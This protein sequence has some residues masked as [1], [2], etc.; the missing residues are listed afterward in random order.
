MKKQPRKGFIRLRAIVSF[1]AM[2][3]MVAG[4][5]MEQDLRS[6]ISDVEQSNVQTT[7][8]PGKEA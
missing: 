6:L 8:D 7:L 5:G 4:I 1:I 3:F 2:G